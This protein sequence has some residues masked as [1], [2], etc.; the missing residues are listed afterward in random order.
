MDTVDRGGRR[1][2]TMDMVEVAAMPRHDHVDAQWQGA[3]DQGEQAQALN[4]ARRLLASLCRKWWGNGASG[5][6]DSILV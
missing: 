5:S 3:G 6:L 1:W 4:D 2:L